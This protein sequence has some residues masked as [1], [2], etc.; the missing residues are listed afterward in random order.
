[1][2]GRHQVSIGNLNF[3]PQEAEAVTKLGTMMAETTD[4]VERP[5]EIKYVLAVCN[6]THIF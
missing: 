5:D 6:R 2:G 1:V 4:C 3:R